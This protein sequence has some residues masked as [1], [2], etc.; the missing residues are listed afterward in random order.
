M[1]IDQDTRQEHRSSSHSN[2]YSGHIGWQ[3]V[4]IMEIEQQF[5]SKYN[6]KN[7]ILLDNQ[8]TTNIFSNKAMVMNTCDTNKIMKLDTNAGWSKISTEQCDVPDFKK[9][10]TIWF[11]DNMMTN[12]LLFG[13]ACDAWYEIN[14]NKERDEFIVTARSIPFNEKELICIFTFRMKMN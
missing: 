4:Q 12:I 7:W 14:Y 2:D 9:L 6:L 8:S 13:L 10:D 5:Y 11:N 1:D 3:G